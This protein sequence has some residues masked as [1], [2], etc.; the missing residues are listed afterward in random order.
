[1]NSTSDN[2]DRRGHCACGA[3]RITASRLT[4]HV[5]SCHCVTCRRWCGGPL[6]TVNCGKSIHI[7][8]LEQVG[9]F[10]SSQWADRGFCRQCGSNLF[11]RLKGGGD[12]YVMAGLFAEDDGDFQFSDQV[13]IDQKPAFYEFANQTSNMTGPELFALVAKGQDPG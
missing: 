6:M 2:E 3:V 5:G 13:F 12:H 9:I 11:Y 1:M 7:D 8:G 10:D 4:G